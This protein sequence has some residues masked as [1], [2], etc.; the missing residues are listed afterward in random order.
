MDLIITTPPSLWSKLPTSKRREQLNEK[1]SSKGA[2]K[3]LPRCANRN[4]KT[5]KRHKDTLP[6]QRYVTARKFSH[7][8]VVFFLGFV[9]R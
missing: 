1:S 3:V 6:V 8:D 4:T 9:V 2:K 5:K 7:L